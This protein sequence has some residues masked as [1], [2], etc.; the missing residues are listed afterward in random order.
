MTFEIKVIDQGDE[1]PLTDAFKPRFDDTIETIKQKIFA[2][3][4]SDDPNDVLFW[5]EFTRIKGLEGIPKGI[6]LAEVTNKTEL[7]VEDLV[8]LL[9]DETPPNVITETQLENLLKKH[10]KGGYPEL[11]KSKLKSA[12]QL[13]H[14]TPDPSF[15]KTAKTLREKLIKQFAKEQTSWSQLKTVE[16]GLMNKIVNRTSDGRYITSLLNALVKFAPQNFKGQIDTPLLFNQLNV[17]EDFPLISIQPTTK[18]PPLFKIWEKIKETHSDTVRKWLIVDKGVEEQLKLPQGLTVRIKVGHNE[19]ALLNLFRSGLINVRCS[20]KEEQ[21]A[22]KTDLEKCLEPIKKFVE[23]INRQRVVFTGDSKLV[24]GKPEILQLDESVQIKTLVSREKLRNKIAKDTKLQFFFALDQ[25][26]KL[27]DDLCKDLKL[28]DDECKKLKKTQIEELAKK[29]GISLK[30]SAFTRNQLNLRYNRVSKRPPVLRRT[31]T[32]EVKLEPAAEG[33]IVIIIKSSGITENTTTIL[34]KDSKSFQQTQHIIDIVLRTIR[35]TDDFKTTSSPIK[36]VK[37]KLKVLKEHGISV[38][39]RSCQEP[40][41]PIVSDVAE[42]IDGSYP[43]I[44]NGTRIICTNPKAP[45]PGYTNKGVVCCFPTDQRQKPNFKKHHDPNQVKD[46]ITDADLQ[47]GKQTILTDKLLQPGRLGVLPDKIGELF[48]GTFRRVGVF[49]DDAFLHAVFAAIKDH[50]KLNSF[51]TF[52]QS[53][54]DFV[55]KGNIFRSLQNGN[56][57]KQMSLREY[58]NL[59]ASGDAN[60]SMLLDAVSKFA[61]IN[62][63]IFNEQAQNI[64][65]YSHWESSKE[66]VA[67]NKPSIFLLLKDESNYEPIFEFNNEDVTKVFGARHKISL[68][69]K[70]LYSFSCTFTPELATNFKHPISAKLTNDELSKNDIPVVFQIVNAHNEVVFVVVKTNDKKVL[71]PVQPSGAV[72]NVPIIELTEDSLKTFKRNATVT[73]KIL[74]TIAEQTKLPI[75]VSSQILKGDTINGF[76]LENGMVVPVKVKSDERRRLNLPVSKANFSASIDTAIKQGLTVEDPRVQLANQVKTLSGLRNQARLE[77][78]A[79]LGKNTSVRDRL[80]N[81]ITDAKISQSKKLAKV[82]SQI[83]KIL[84]IVTIKTTVK[85][86]IGTVKQSCF[87]TTNGTTCNELPWCKWVQSKCKMEFPKQF[88]ESLANAIAHEIVTDTVRKSILKQRLILPVLTTQQ[89]KGEVVLFDLQSAQAWLKGEPIR[90][91]AN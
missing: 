36:R 69:V 17:S 22:T 16:D 81:I 40:R 13:A 82:K 27:K 14:Q 80:D 85:N 66:F 59:L 21:H 12:L 57:G 87:E 3:Q 84:K 34:L 83:V 41:Q 23:L 50:L 15:I 42:P 56:V 5:T 88:K 64:V 61:G 37:S 75:G 24:L 33:K 49:Q 6:V 4:D 32:G 73:Q 19:W 72:L 30:T 70:D 53:L 11:S 7:I 91:R 68:L 20:W 10:Q 65:C 63:W 46:E 77:I 51:E 43:L 28:D 71:I 79:W 86:V 60:H 39:S 29:K 9:E 54:V 52:K 89:V 62:I 26:T 47:L 67:P 48:K 76:V 58:Q 18:E 44:I 74:N 31:R 55:S 2:G 35:I 45:Y 90:R 78:S 38:D 8:T 25:E 1:I